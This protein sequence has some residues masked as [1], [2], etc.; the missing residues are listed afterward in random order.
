MKKE[1]HDYVASLRTFTDRQLDFYE[2]TRAQARE[3]LI[4][5]LQVFHTDIRGDLVDIDRLYDY[6]MEIGDSGICRFDR[7]VIGFL[8]RNADFERFVNAKIYSGLSCREAVKQM[9]TICALNSPKGIKSSRAWYFLSHYINWS[10]TKKREYEG[11]SL[12]LL[13]ERHNEDLDSWFYQNG[14]YHDNDRLV[15]SEGSLAEIGQSI[16]RF[17]EGPCH[18]VLE[19]EIALRI[20]ISAFLSTTDNIVG[21]I[22]DLQHDGF[23]IGKSERSMRI[24]IDGVKR[25]LAAWF[26]VDDLSS[27]LRKTFVDVNEAIYSMNDWFM[28]I[29]NV[30]TIEE[31]KKI[32]EK[33]LKERERVH[34]QSVT[35]GNDVDLY[36][37]QST[38]HSAGIKTKIRHYGGIEVLE[39]WCSVSSQKKRYG[40]TTYVYSNGGYIDFKTDTTGVAN[41]LLR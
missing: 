15:G 3:V 23:G 5:F 32:A 35:K 33:D 14:L 8:E 12:E 11:R 9:F 28:K 6:A 30:K 4:A 2:K 21:I 38:Y 24:I 31:A 26:V 34:K 40:P 13:M 29:A 22:T 20:G 27:R 25:R 18:N 36:S 41:D 17:I 7:M 39:L 19:R 1:T 16:K 10:T 37:I